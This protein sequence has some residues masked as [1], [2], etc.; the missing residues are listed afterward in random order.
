MGLN[1]NIQIF[2]LNK[3]NPED[4]RNGNVAHNIT[5]NK[6]LQ[7]NKFNLDINKRYQ[8]NNNS[9]I[10]GGVGKTLKL[11][12]SAATLGAAVYASQ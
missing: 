12:G 2:L 10:K 5:E 9:N 3:F 7:N 11:T 8:V 4:F 1:I 6:Y